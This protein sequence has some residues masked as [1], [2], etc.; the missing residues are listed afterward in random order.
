MNRI[1]PE[2]TYLFTKSGNE[3]RT[4]A[5]T[6]RYRGQAMW[7]VERV[8]GASAGKRMDVPECALMPVQDDDHVLFVDTP[9]GNACLVLE[10]AGR[11][12]MVRSFDVQGHNAL[13]MAFEPQ[14][15]GFENLDTASA[16]ARRLNLSTKVRYGDVVLCNTEMRAKT[17]EELERTLRVAQVRVFRHDAV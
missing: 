3:V 10:R 9:V 1:K 5:P 11:S 2:Q 13:G 15:P 17:I 8:S 6:T 4:I 7:E 16:V 14:V 12:F